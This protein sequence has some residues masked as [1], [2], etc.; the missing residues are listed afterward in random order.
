MVQFIMAD[1]WCVC[2]CGCVYHIFLI[3][4]SVDG[5]LFCVHVLAVVDSA[6]MNTEVQFKLKAVEIYHIKTI[7][8]ESLV[9]QW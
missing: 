8:R 2:V 7:S 3:H 1:V 4:S 6:A 5:H 9:A